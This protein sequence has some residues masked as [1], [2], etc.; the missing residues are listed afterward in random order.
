MRDSAARLRPDLRV[1]WINDSLPALATLSR[2]GLSFDLIL[3]SAVW[4]HVAPIDRVRAFRKLI[5]LL[6]PGGLIAITLR[7]GP[8]EPARGMHPVSL[9]EL[10]TLARGHGTFIQSSIEA[11]DALGRPDVRWTQVAIRLPDDGTGALPLLRHVILNDDKS[12]TY[13]LALLRSLCRIADGA[14]GFAA[15]CDDDFVSLPLGLVA[16]TWVR[17]FQPLLAGGLPQSPS[18]LGYERLGFVKE[19]FRKLADVSHL[20]LR[21]GMAFSGD[22]GA[23][24]HKALKDAAETIA[25][26]PATYMT[27]PNGGPILPVIRTV[28][29]SGPSRVLLDRDYL[30]SFGDMRIPRHLWAAL[31]R[32]DVWIEPALVAEWS[33]LIKFYA[34]RQG[35]TVDDAAIAVAMAW[36]EPTRDVGLARERALVLVAADQL[37]CVWSGR[38][39]INHS[40]DV[41]HCLPW[42]AWPCGDLWNLMPAHRYINQKEKRARLPSDRVL[43]TAQDRI[44]HWWEAGFI[45][46]GPQLAQRFW[47][48]ANSSLPSMRIANTSTSDLFDALCLQRMRL[49]HDQ[50]VPEWGGEPQVVGG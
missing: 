10:E 26:M 14:A 37:F 30:S 18:N 12:S 2:T 4:M 22:T 3:L 29:R 25:K 50:Q 45:A 41:D 5:N 16:L 23:T 44:L 11:N 1:R 24:L 40:L 9:A 31:Q 17:L 34:S 21:V 32:F 20:D 35:R 49:R 33:R 47:L 43:R 8:A 38:R 6:K 36:D 48:E 7:H 28:T 46:A 19:A 42:S 13:K 27:Y 39:L 15:E